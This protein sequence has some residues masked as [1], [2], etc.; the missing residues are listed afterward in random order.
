MNIIPC[1]QVPAQKF[2]I[3]LAGQNCTITLYQK[4]TG[5]FLD[6]TLNDVVLFTGVIC[7]NRVR[8]VREAYLGFIGDLSF[9]DTQG[10]DDPVYTGLN[11]RWLFVYLAPSDIV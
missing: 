6:L 3:Q 8:L 1:Q 7:R 4:T 11:D 2:N 9:I 10:V 5:L